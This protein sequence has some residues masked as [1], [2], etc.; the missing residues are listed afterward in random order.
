MNPSSVSGHCRVTVI[1]PTRRVDVALPE[2]VPL[3][4]LLPEMLR[5]VRG[6]NSGG[7]GVGGNGVSD[8]SGGIGLSGYVLT[9][10][11]G[12]VLDTASSINAQG[13]LHGEFLRLRPVG[14]LV[15][16]PVHDEIAD[17]VALAVLGIGRQWTAAALRAV[18]LA[19]G[20]LAL[21]LGAVVLWFSASRYPGSF[22]GRT[23]VV[24]GVM[25]VV[26]F[27][28]GVHR[29]RST[30]RRTGFSAGPRR[31]GNVRAVG[32]HGGR[33]LAGVRAVGDGGARDSRGD[34]A[35]GVV[36][37]TC[38]LPYAFLSGFGV[39]ATNIVQ[40]LGRTEFT[41]GMA[42]FCIIAMA[43]IPALGRRL[44]A[45]VAGVAVGVVGT[46]AG[47]AMALLHTTPLAVAAVIAACCAAAAAA[48]P[49]AAL[50]AVRFPIEP[51]TGS[52][53]PGDFDNDPLDI[54]A[55]TAAIEHADEILTGLAVGVGA[56]VL[57]CV[58]VLSF[59][60]PSVATGTTG[61]QRTWALLLA[62]IIAATLI[63]HARMYRQRA[64]VLAL[65]I[66][67][68]LSLALM[69]AAIS[70]HASP[71]V[72]ATWLP[73]TMAA[74]AAIAF[75]T[76]TLRARRGTLEAILP[77]TWGRAV[78]SFESG[79]LLAVLPVLLA[80][81]GLYGEARGLGS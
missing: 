57:A 39:L 73:A 36:L 3:A 68:V 45:A 37:T 19:V 63:C 15:E 23:S 75:G 42:T 52:A 76:S 35:A 50:R 22:H 47:I 49:A 11:D 78:D 66:S 56:I 77:P 34:Y 28:V 1:S 71:M 5:L 59:P 29:A 25:A 64:Q 20:A 6:G 21:V 53:D 51:P 62:G 61:P 69:A 46:A 38:A 81:L 41:I 54:E 33:E 80:V 12:A 16:P 40:G 55:V 70:F 24:A 72:R 26:L 30:G 44:E 9:G 4:E 60:S 17:A 7:I 48:L 79:L 65:T 58:A 31:V 32:G 67:G 10:P 13:I 27:A 18:S 14:E 74:A 43:T 2:D 8:G